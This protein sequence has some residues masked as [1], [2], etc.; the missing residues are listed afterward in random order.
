[1]A[2]PNLWGAYVL[3]GRISRI[4]KKPIVLYLPIS[5]DK[6]QLISATLKLSDLPKS[7]SNLVTAVNYENYYDLWQ[8]LENYANGLNGVVT[9]IQILKTIMKSAKEK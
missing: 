6:D 7:I 5:R 8:Q 9:Y 1:M 2:T 4:T 3:D